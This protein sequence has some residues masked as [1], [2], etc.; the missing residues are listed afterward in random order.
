ML[1]R[2]V[3]ESLESNLEMNNLNTYTSANREAHA[4]AAT[5]IKDIWAVEFGVPGAGATSPGGIK[6]PV[7]FRGRNEM[8]PNTQSIDR[9]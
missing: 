2:V 4:K 6:D 5:P 8:L 7:S 1:T 3:S 9:L